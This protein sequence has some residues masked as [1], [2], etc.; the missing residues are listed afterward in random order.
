[1]AGAPVDPRRSSGRALDLACGTGAVTLWLA[2]GGM[3]VLAVDVSPAAIALLEAAAHAAGL[4]DLVD[5]RVAD[6]DLGLP[7]PGPF[8]IIVCQR[9]RD[10]QL[11]PAIAAALAPGGHACVTVLSAVDRD[12]PPGRFH[13]EPGE[14][15]DAF[16]DPE[17]DVLAHAERDGT[18]SIVIHRPDS[19]ATLHR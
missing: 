14:L 18:A 15:L 10:P 9:F 11:Y 8:D 16:D 5:G 2:A 6:L 4:A 13:A 12:G 19:D 3:D 7:D 1:M 17:L